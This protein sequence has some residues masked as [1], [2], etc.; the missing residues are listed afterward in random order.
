[1][2]RSPYRTGAVVG[3]AC[4]GVAGVLL[5]GG[6]LDPPAGP[7]S[8]TYKTLNEIEPRTPISALPV[9]ITQPGSYY[10]TG[11]LTGVP[12]QSGITV[13]ASDVSID[14]KGF[15]LQGVPGSL[16]GITPGLAPGL[17]NLTVSGGT[18]RS[19]GG[20]GLVGVDGTTVARVEARGNAGRGIVLDRA[21]PK[22][23][24]S[25]A[26]GNGGDGIILGVDS[27]SWGIEATANGGAGII[28]G[29]GGHSGW[30]IVEGNGIGSAGLGL[31]GGAGVTIVN[32]TATGNGGGGIRLLDKSS[33]QLVKASANGGDGIALGIDTT[34]V[35]CTCFNNT[36]NGL[37][38][39]PGSTL[40]NC[41]ASG[42]GAN[43]ILIT[44]NNIPPRSATALLTACVAR[45]NGGVGICSFQWGVGRGMTMVSCIAELNISHGFSLA[46]EATLDRCVSRSN[47][48]V[49]VNAASKDACY[50]TLSE[51]NTGD[52]FIVGGDSELTGC[53]SRNNGGVGFKATDDNAPAKTAGCVA[54]GNQ[55]DGFRVGS[56]W[57]V[58]GCTARGGAAGA[59]GAGIRV[60]GASNRIEGNHVLA[61]ASGGLIVVGTGNLIIGNNAGGNSAA[62]YSIAGGNIF[63]PIVTS[64]TVDTATNPNSNFEF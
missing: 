47:G 54:E 12:G 37:V 7:V 24:K 18:I 44:D 1:M 57:M 40:N 20:D 55:G 49:G 61:N 21:S 2:K 10:L 16:N 60:I 32:V 52:G 23:E 38:A 19:W 62:N 5:Y 36:G 22:L 26:I 6:P 45:G 17:T 48:G 4:I 64:A 34:P 31:S 15:T 46:C 27:Y 43:G 42:N 25:N 51:G 41:T 50:M 53:T 30:I 59:V 8:S 14:L 58:S 56:G 29:D 35:E 28:L 11:S 39:G 13:N 33:P 9:T 63:G 3:L